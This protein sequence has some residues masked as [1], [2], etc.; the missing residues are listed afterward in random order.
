[1][2]DDLVKRLLKGLCDEGHLQQRDT[3]SALC[4]EAAL[5]I[6]KLEATH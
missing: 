1:M 2:I 4:F 3:Y 5:C 6:K